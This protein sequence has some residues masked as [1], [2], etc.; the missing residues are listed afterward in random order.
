VIVSGRLARGQWASLPAAAKK[1]LEVVT[2]YLLPHDQDA[3]LASFRIWLELRKFPVVDEAMQNELFF[4]ASYM[5]ATISEMLDNLY[6]DYLLERV[7]NM[8]TVQ[9]SLRAVDES[10]MRALAGR[11]GAMIAHYGPETSPE[12]IHRSTLERVTNIKSRQTGTSIYPALSLGAGQRHASKGAYLA[13][14]AGP[15]LAD[16]V[17]DTGLIIP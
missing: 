16:L 5:T 1:S 11:P 7:E 9:E 8:L 10:R 3:N 6:A 14:V 17:S 4:A 13:R 15:G 2:P 12:G